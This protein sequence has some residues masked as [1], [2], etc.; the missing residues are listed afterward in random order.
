MNWFLVGDVALLSACVI[1]QAIV[2][3]KLRR[4]LDALRRARFLN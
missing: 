3:Y 1:Y 2:I 4:E